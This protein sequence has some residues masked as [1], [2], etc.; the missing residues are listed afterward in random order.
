[1]VKTQ[2][3]MSLTLSDIETLLNDIPGH[4]YWKDKLGV[5][6]GCNLRQAQSFGFSVINEV[7]GKS[8]FELLA[9]EDAEI[10]RSNDILVMKCGKPLVLEETT[11]YNGKKRTFLSH[12]VPIKNTEGHS[13]GILG[14]SLDITHQK[15]LEQQL[16][17]SNRLLKQSLDRQKIL[18]IELIEKNHQLEA[19]LRGHKEKV[20]A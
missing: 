3:Q 4:I 9:H 6:L 18:E 20:V 10:L 12:K 1:M 2:M 13:I 17:K 11:E 5:I 7:V 15:E 8:D 14:V 16:V 19:I